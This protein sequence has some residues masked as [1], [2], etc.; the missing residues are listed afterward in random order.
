MIVVC[1]GLRVVQL[2][3]READVYERL[4]KVTERSITSSAE[5]LLEEGAKAGSTRTC[6]ICMETAKP[7]LMSSCRHLA[8]QACWEVSPHHT[9]VRSVPLRRG[10]EI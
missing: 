1:L 3:R 6:N 2:R 9:T 10:A 7:I 5:R 8:C 4:C